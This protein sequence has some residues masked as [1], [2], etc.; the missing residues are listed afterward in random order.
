MKKKS[1]SAKKTR[2]KKILHNLKEKKISQIYKN[3]EIFISKEI[4]EKSFGVA[5]SG[6]ADSLSLAFLSKCLSLKKKFKVKF[7]IVHHKLRKNSSNEA[8]KVKLLLNKFGI[9]SKI[10]NWNGKKPKSNIQSVAREKRYLLLN[11][12]CKIDKIKNILLGHHADDRNE[13]FF[14]RLIRGSGLKGLVSLNKSSYNN[15]LKIKILRP[16]M[17]LKKKDLTFISKKV[18]NFYVKDPS[19]NNE[20]FQRI[21]VRKLINNLEKEGLDKNKIELTINNLQSS[22]ETIR[23][24]VE[25]NIK[26]NSLYLKNQNKFILKLKFFDEPI[27]VSFR[28]ISKILLLIS[29]R[30]YSPRGKSI[31]SLISNI[32]SKNFSKA[33]LGRC[34]IEKINETVLITREN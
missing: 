7:F 26:N 5:V 1:L 24:Y 28:S 32:K 21:R 10:L 30:Y 22:D 19:N 20:D 27:D 2:H 23:H 31:L 11:N 16:L 13:N 33:T 12:A 18:F 6:G 14:I 9:K 34:F 8:V 17:D 3:F 4:K 25:K 29:G 15:S